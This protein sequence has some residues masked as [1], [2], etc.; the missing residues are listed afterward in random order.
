MDYDRPCS[1]CSNKM[2]DNKLEALLN[3]NLAQTLKEPRRAAWS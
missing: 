1:G 2:E 3:E